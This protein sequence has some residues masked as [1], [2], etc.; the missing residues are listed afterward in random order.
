MK[1]YSNKQ[2]VSIEFSDFRKCVQASYFEGRERSFLSSYIP[3][4]FYINLTGTRICPDEYGLV[5]IDGKTLWKPRVIICF[6]NNEKIEKIFETS[7][8]AKEYFFKIKTEN[9][10]N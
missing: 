2:I 3:A 9:N 8:Q 7:E 10:L 1:A 6:S 4:G 5:F